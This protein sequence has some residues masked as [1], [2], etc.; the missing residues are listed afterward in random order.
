RVKGS[1]DNLSCPIDERVDRLLAHLLCEVALVRG[2]IQRT[3][4]APTESHKARDD[5]VH[6]AQLV[7]GCALDESAQL[8]HESVAIHSTL[9]GTVGSSFPRSVAI[10]SRSLMARL[11]CPLISRSS[12][13]S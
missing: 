6:D 2:E 8:T 11:V 12:W 13:K 5:G 4:V 7:I 3:V 9:P 1:L 10:C